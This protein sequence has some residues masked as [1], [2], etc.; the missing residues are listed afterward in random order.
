MKTFFSFK[1][2][3]AVG[4]VALLLFISCQPEEIIETSVV[5]E[6]LD[7]TE[8]AEESA[9]TLRNNS[10]LIFPTNA[11]LFGKCSE[12]WVI[13]FGKASVSLDCESIFVNQL[14]S[15]H[16]K[17]V[18]PFGSSIG[19]FTDEY[20]ITK[21]Q[22]VF[23]SPAFI[24]Y[25]YPC[26]AEFEFEPAEGQSLEDFLK[27]LAKE[28]IDAIE[29]LEVIIDGNIVYDPKAYRT[30]TDLFYF[31]GNPDLA[32]C[33]DPCITGEE[34]PAIIDGYFMMLKKFKVGRHTVVVRGEVPSDDFKYE[35]T[36]I[37]NVTK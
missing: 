21:N 18:A 36:F 2:G 9:T 19:D 13:E 30:S 37:L 15:L 1:I 10:A 7:M 12:E 27:E 8:N 6:N 16:E 25:D 34:Q 22:F 4:L 29:T 31:T 17:V 32:E 35:V 3:T 26:P 24:L 20:T 11:R 23:L 14:L 33:Y 28:S 5:E